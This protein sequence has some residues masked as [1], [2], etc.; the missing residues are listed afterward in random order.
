MWVVAACEG[1]ISLFNKDAEGSL[2]PLSLSGQTVFA[3]PDHF[4][5][6]IDS[7]D[8]AR[9]FDQLVIIGSGNDIAWVHAS[10]SDSATRHIVAEIEYPLIAG[11]FKEQ[12]FLHLTMA[13]KNVFSG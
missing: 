3:S 7:A 13:L 2:K 6:S 1:M 12:D 11:W 4:K 8:D 10:L 9:Q 5:K